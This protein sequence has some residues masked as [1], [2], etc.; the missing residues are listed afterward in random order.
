MSSEKYTAASTSEADKVID[1]LNE[2]REEQKPVSYSCKNCGCT[3]YS[4]RSPLGGPKIKVCDNCNQKWYAARGNLAP[5][6]PQNL[7]HK[8]GS[9][10]GPIKSRPKPK[11]AKHQ[12]TY[13]SKGKKR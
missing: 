7:N 11:P 9:T 4:V 12:P 10:K 5:L 1:A 3:S 8:Q 2:V 13:R 6:M